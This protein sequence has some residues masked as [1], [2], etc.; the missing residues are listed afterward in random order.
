MESSISKSIRIK[1]LRALCKSC[2]LDISGTKKD[3][4]NRLHLYN[5]NSNIYHE[6]LEK[7]IINE[8]KNEN[9]ENI[10]NNQEFINNKKEDETKNMMKD[11]DIEY[12]ECLRN[13]MI[14][15]ATKIINNNESL[16]SLTN[17]HLIYYLLENFHY[18]EYKNIIDMSNNELKELLKNKTKIEE[19]KEEVK[20][21]V[22]EED[23]SKKKKKKKPTKSN[24][25]N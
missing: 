7:N 10:E 9:I 11:Q 3:L 1:D 17:E 12:Y 22:T 25:K 4:R 24:V 19:V 18:L 15:D 6:N 16:D 20:E 13:D 8:S 2:N 23:L 5:L 14:K 21:E